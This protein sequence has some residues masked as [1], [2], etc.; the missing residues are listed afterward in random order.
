VNGTSTNQIEKDTE[1]TWKCEGL[2]GGD[3]VNCSESKLES[4]YADRDDDTYGNATDWRELPGPLDPY[5]TLDNTDCNDYEALEN[6]GNIEGPSAV[7]CK[8]G[9]DNDCDGLRDCKDPDCASDI[10]CCYSTEATV[11]YVNLG[12]CECVNKALA[13]CNDVRLNV[14]VTTMLADGN[15][16]E[17]AP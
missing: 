16:V 5:T 8:D 2:I 7:N 6:P 11:C 14:S 13:E 15:C 9:L 12:T 10:V 17:V 1:W 3:T 4:Y